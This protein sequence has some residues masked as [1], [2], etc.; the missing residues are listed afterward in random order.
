MRPRHPLFP[1]NPFSDSQRSKKGE[2]AAT[3]ADDRQAGREAAE[4]LDWLSCESEGD[5]VMAFPKSRIMYIEYKGNDVIGP[6]RIGRVTF[7]KTGKTLYYA[8][9]TFERLTPC[10]YKRNYYDVATGETYWISGCK[11]D[12]NDGLYGG[13]DAE[14]DEDVRVEY[15]TTIRR[16]PDNVAS[17]TVNR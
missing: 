14:I 1:Q 5:F 17:T 11:R 3:H 4:P 10:G 8:G 13:C 16:K 15:W 6:S 7:S 2:H 9:K 12:G